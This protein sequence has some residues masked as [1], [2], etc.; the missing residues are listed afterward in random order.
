MNSD[1]T[2]EPHLNSDVTPSRALALPV[3]QCPTLLRLLLGKLAILGDSSSVFEEF[4]TVTAL[5]WI[6]LHNLYSGHYSL[7]YVINDYLQLFAMI[8]MMLHH[9]IFASK[10]IY[11]IQILFNPGGLFAYLQ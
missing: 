8:G 6:P 10:H 1:S 11:V 9:S 7:R 3:A 2:L 5:F 4:I